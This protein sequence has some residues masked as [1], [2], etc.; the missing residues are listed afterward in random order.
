MIMP[1][2]RNFE[3]EIIENN[4]SCEETSQEEEISAENEGGYINP[5]DFTAPFFNLKPSDYL[6]EKLDIKKSAKT[7]GLG[8]LFMQ[9]FIVILNIVIISAAQILRIFKV[10]DINLLSDPAIL[11]TEQIIFSL[12]SFTIPFIISFKISKIRIS[13][14]ISFEKWE[15]E[16][17][18]PF[19]LFGVGFCAFANIASSAAGSIFESFG[20]EYNVN[21][22]EG[23]KGIFG[24]FLSLIATV[25]TPALVEEFVCRGLILGHLKKY[26]ESFAII[27]SSIL[28]GLMHSN[29]EQ[30]PF[31]FLVGLI[32]GYIT[33]KSNSIW[34]AV[35]VHGFNNFISVAF[36]YLF[37][38]V[39]VQI[40]NI[41]YTLFLNISLLAGIAGVWLLRKRT[42]AYNLMASDLK[43][44]EK[45][46]Y[47]YFFSNPFIIIFV[48]ICLVDSL[49]FFV[50]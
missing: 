22:P 19:L 1:E 18:I 6:Y 32:L 35:I 24:F 34:P 17:F 7:V 28:F 16:T 29:F 4:S 40:Q 38:G 50:I 15:K 25:I 42:D 39:S 44:E 45:H 33:V 13:N 9:L 5:P 12:I 30:I 23:P 2:E 3:Q 46:K 26:G 47:K 37:S 27:V 8:F 10:T 49:A 36:E 14:L 20:I 21:F 31:A 11:Q 48:V 43:T 41:I